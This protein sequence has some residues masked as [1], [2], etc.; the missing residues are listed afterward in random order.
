M[1]DVI[2]WG[3]VGV[4]WRAMMSE[5]KLKDRAERHRGVCGMYLHTERGGKMRERL[6]RNQGSQEPL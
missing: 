3:T 4:S 6:Y 1:R 5:L 2:V